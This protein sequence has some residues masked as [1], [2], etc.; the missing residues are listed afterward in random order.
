[1]LPGDLLDVLQTTGFLLKK[2]LDR[3]PKL[4][5]VLLIGPQL[6][7]RPAEN[8]GPPGAG[9]PRPCCCWVDSPKTWNP[10]CVYG[11]VIFGIMEKELIT[12]KITSTRARM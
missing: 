5:I 8:P 1:M 9:L 3:I 6:W 12:Q 7:P 4:S 2:G 11:V 10:L